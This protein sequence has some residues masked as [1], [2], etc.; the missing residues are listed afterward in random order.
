MGRIKGPGPGPGP[1]SSI[2]NAIPSAKGPPAFAIA[3]SGSIE[4]AGVGEGVEE[5]KLL[6][7]QTYA[8][9]LVKWKAA[10]LRESTVDQGFYATLDVK[11]T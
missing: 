4:E 8:H 5:G 2:L 3:T 1:V 11:P 10:R 7:R 6:V 9:V